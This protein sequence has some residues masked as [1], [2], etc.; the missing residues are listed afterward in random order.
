MRV[1]LS[2]MSQGPLWTLVDDD[3]S[4]CVGQRILYKRDDKHETLVWLDDPKL[5]AEETARF[6]V[7]HGDERMPPGGVW[8]RVPAG[9]CVACAMQ[10]CP[11]HEP[12][13]MRM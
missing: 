1:L 12:A 7:V 4:G 13:T 8:L 11:L 6:G 2:K 10:A 5:F 3:D 9:I